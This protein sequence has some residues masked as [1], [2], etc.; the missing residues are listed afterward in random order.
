MNKFYLVVITIFFSSHMMSQRA[1]ELA[2]TGSQ[3]MSNDKSISK[4]RLDFSGYGLGVRA[5]VSKSKCAFQAAILFTKM[6]L[7][8]ITYQSDEAAQNTILPV[9]TECLEAQLAVRHTFNTYKKVI[10]FISAGC[11]NFYVLR[12]SNYNAY[13]DPEIM[14]NKN[15]IRDSRYNFAFR[16]STGIKCKL[17]QHL[18]LDLEPDLKYFPFNST[19][20]SNNLVIGLGLTLNFLFP[21]KHHEL[22]E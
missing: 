4:G 21:E 11:A 14:A 17:D 19:N 5:T 8:S 10:P 13:S 3:H 18:S 2:L 6:E 1:Y 9:Q 22:V 16:A 7:G 15:Q 12:H 20:Y